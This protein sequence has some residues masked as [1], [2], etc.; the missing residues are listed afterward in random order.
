MTTFSGLKIANLKK[1][2]SNKFPII[3]NYTLYDFFTHTSTCT[4]N[5]P[6]QNEFFL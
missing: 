3:H 5:N 6:I 1:K 4:Y 2:K